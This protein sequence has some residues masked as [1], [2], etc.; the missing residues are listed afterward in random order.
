[1]KEILRTN[2]LVLISYVGHLLAEAGIAHTLFDAH[3]SA[4]EGSIGAFPR[5]IMVDED[6][7]AAARRVLVNASITSGV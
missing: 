7:F 2:D 4:V 1:M 3:I 6:D 5:R